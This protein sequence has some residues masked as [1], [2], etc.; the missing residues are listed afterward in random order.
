MAKTVLY[1]AKISCDWGDL[2]QSTYSLDKEK[3]I[4]NAIENGYEFNEL[5][6]DYRKEMDYEDWYLDI[7][8]HEL[9]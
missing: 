6:K 3:L 1:E 2:G 7:V 4:K 8:E 9:L 5:H